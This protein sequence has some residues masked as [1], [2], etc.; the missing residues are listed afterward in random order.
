MSKNRDVGQKM[1]A[2]Y[3]NDL[4]NITDRQILKYHTISSI[5]LNSYTGNSEASRSLIRS[6]YGLCSKM[7]E[8]ADD[9]LTAYE[10]DASQ[11]DIINA[12]HTANNSKTIIAAIKRMK[13]RPSGYSRS[14]IFFAIISYK[15]HNSPDIEV[16]LGIANE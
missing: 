1:R 10:E 13:I 6:T 2:D 15:Y 5:I 16:R 14:I 11:A 12:I 9:L 4:K 8:Y 7:G 3:F